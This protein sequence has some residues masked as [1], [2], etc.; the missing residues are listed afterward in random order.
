MMYK[1]LEHGRYQRFEHTAHYSFC[2]RTKRNEKYH[3]SY[4]F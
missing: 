2:N 3:E 4:K 1:D